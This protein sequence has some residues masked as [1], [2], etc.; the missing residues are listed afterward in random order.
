MDFIEIRFKTMY[1]A[2]PTPEMCHSERSEASGQVRMVMF[3]FT[4]QQ[5]PATL[6]CKG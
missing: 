2:M 5:I 4:G 6:P 1:S 3:P